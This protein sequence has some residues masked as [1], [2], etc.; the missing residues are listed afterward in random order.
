MNTI[1]KRTLTITCAEGETVERKQH[2]CFIHNLHA[3][4]LKQKPL[5]Q[6]RCEQTAQ[7]G[8]TYC[9]NGLAEGTLMTLRELT[10]KSGV[11]FTYSRHGKIIYTAV[12][13]DGDTNCDMHLAALLHKVRFTLTLTEAIKKPE[14]PT[15]LMKA[16]KP[17]SEPEEYA[18]KVGDV[19]RAID[20]DE[21]VSM[22]LD[23]PSTL[24]YQIS[25]SCVC[26]ERRR[27]EAL[28]RATVS[29]LQN[30]HPKETGILMQ[31][32]GLKENGR[33]CGHLV[34]SPLATV[35]N[36]SVKFD[37]AYY[38]GLTPTQRNLKFALDIIV[39]LLVGI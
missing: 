28:I 38:G 11:E 1:Q 3:D 8:V 16:V 29:Y 32:F 15:E 10:D 7:E 14:S 39:N 24:S 18:I 9:S 17:Q 25:N 31:G 33:I 6:W 13:T 23:K 35:A 36:A 22:I 2:T 20:V 19:F 26:P 27:K 37:K 30:V 21:L 5:I 4:I 12:E 34:T